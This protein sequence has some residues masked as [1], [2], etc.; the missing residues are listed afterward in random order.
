M[1]HKYQVTIEKLNSLIQEKFNQIHEFEIHIHLCSKYSKI[2]EYQEQIS[3]LEQEISEL[4]KGF[5]NKHAKL[6]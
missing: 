3:Q 2:Q 6:T 1:T 4:Q 5:T